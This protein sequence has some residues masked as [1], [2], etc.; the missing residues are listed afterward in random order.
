MRQ[1][2]TPRTRFLALLLTLVCMLGL[3]PATAL[4][5]DVPATIKMDDRTYSSTH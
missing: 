2:H 4:A 1:D 3:L 5:A